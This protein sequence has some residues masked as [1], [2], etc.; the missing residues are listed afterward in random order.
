MKFSIIKPLHKKGTTKEFENYRP[1][2]L[3]TVFSNILEK[4]IRGSTL[5][6]RL[7]IYLSD[8]QFGFREKLST[9]SATNALIN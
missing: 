7:I 1:I 9:G 2:S 5:T 4:N 6:S 8:E 3:L